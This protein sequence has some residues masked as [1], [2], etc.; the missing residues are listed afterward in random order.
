MFAKTNIEKPM[1]PGAAETEALA[2]LRTAEQR[3][4]VVR[5]RQ[6]DIAAEITRLTGL[7]WAAGLTAERQ[8]LDQAAQA[9]LDGAEEVDLPSIE[10]RLR[11]LQAD[12]PVVKRAV[13]I[14][15]QDL[16]AAR[17]HHAGEVVRRLRPAH[18]AAC[19]RIASALAELAAANAAE[20]EIR[21]QVPGGG[22]QL[23]AADFPGVGD[24]HRHAGTPASWWFQNAHRL[25]LLNEAEAMAAE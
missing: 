12:L 19:R 15:R 22:P 21:R 17:S 23:P 24:P 9:L 6:A 5:S 20:I 2:A 1:E 25:G 18:L 13:E 8:A 3:F 7:Q 10:D 14:A 11:K 4:G 16:A